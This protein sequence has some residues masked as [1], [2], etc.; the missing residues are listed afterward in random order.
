MPTVFFLSFQAL[1]PHFF[2]SQDPRGCPHGDHIRLH[3]A[4]HGP[5]HLRPPGAN[6]VDGSVVGDEV[7]LQA[8]DL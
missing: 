2:H 5:Q 1:T 7:R 4:P 8:G 6:D 3:G